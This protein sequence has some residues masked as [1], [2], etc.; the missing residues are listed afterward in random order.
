MKLNIPIK[1][2][3][4]LK[5]VLEKVRSSEQLEALL[6]CSNITAIDRMGYT[7]HGPTHVAIV[8]NI[9][10]KLLRNLFDAGVETS[11]EQHFQLTRDDAEVVVVLGSILHDVGHII[12]R[13]DHTN[14]SIMVANSILPK[15]LE[16]VYSQR[17]QAII[18]SEVMHSIACHDMEYS[19]LTVE[20]GIVCI[21]DAL[22][23]KEG[24]ARI[25]FDA[26]KV[27]IHSVSALAIDDV[28]IST[29]EKPIMIKVKMSNSA[30]IFQIDNL[31]KPKLNTSGLKEYVQISVEIKGEE[32]R[33]LENFE[34]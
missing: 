16:E 3:I 32:K 14:F 7:D 30:G 21:A 22:D 15:F 1:D 11:I 17:E 23:M 2:N 4:K 5:K 8:S 25:P 13:K 9:A 6:E 10:L 19:P 29:G 18:T 31:L 33:I 34:L 24:R 26:G 28:E 12:H 20:A 27:D